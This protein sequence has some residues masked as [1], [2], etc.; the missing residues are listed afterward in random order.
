VLIVMEQKDRYYKGQSLS[1]E[2][3]RERERGGGGE[4]VEMLHKPVM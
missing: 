2:R 3:E 4:R 1:K